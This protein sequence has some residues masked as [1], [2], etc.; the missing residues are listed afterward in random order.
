MKLFT[1]MRDVD[2]SGVSG[3]GEVAEGVEFSDGAV[4]L[5]WRGEAGSTAIH[6]NIENV[7]R[8]HGH[9]GATRIVYE[10]CP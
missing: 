8:V 3:L 4:V 6:D 10:D 7:K 1:L 5:R 9:D 2:P